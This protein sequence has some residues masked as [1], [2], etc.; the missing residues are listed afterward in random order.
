MFGFFRRSSSDEKTSNGHSE[1][2]SVVGK[3]S[4]VDGSFDLEEDDLRVDGA[5]KGEVQTR[6]RAHV[7]P[8]GSVVGDVRAD[9]IRIAGGV[10]GVLCARQ[11]LIILES[12]TVYGILCADSITLEDGAEFEGGLCD[13]EERISVLKEV[14]A[15]PD[16]YTLSDFLS[17]LDE[18]ATRQKSVSGRRSQ[19]RSFDPGSPSR[20][21]NGH[22]D[23]SGQ[24]D[25]ISPAANSASASSTNGHSS[26]EASDE[27]D[28]SESEPLSS[29][30]QW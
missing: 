2:L 4:T 23:G 21:E 5:L 25:E 7:A 11:R 26:D 10:K 19:R 3:G 9:S 27:S 29:K 12:A 18:K 14:L 8:G 13:A 16:T 30:M 1:A 15:T 28:P 6:G 20:P 24:G 22:T 17:S